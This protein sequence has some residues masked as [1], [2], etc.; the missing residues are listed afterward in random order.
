MSLNMSN[1]DVKSE[2]KKPLSFDNNNI[3]ARKMSIASSSR[4]AIHHDVEMEMIQNINHSFFSPPSTSSQNNLTQISLSPLNCRPLGISQPIR[5]NIPQ[6]RGKSLPSTNV[7]L[8]RRSH[9]LYN[10]FY[11]I[12]I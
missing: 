8:T 6:V 7:V 2:K 11:K 12:T 9:R 5:I 4:V 3:M 1:E 10:D